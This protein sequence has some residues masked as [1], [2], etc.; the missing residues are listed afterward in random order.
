MKY[1]LFRNRL[2]TQVKTN[3]FLEVLPL[4]NGSFRLFFDVDASTDIP[5]LADGDGLDEMEN[6]AHLHVSADFDISLPFEPGMEKG[7]EYFNNWQFSPYEQERSLFESYLRD[8]VVRD[9]FRI[10]YYDGEHH[11]PLFN[12]IRVSKNK[13]GQCNLYWECYGLEESEF[14]E[15]VDTESGAFLWQD[16]VFV[17]N[18]PIEIKLKRKN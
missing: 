18:W 4:E 16:P 14:K 5:D 6:H 1:L 11:M 8:E 15:I 10:M 9:A 12:L 13:R 7:L 2:F 17:V 3:G